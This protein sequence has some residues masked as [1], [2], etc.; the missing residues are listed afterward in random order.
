MQI[1]DLCKG[2]KQ[3]FGDITQ[4]SRGGGKNL[5]LKIAGQRGGG[6]GE[7]IRAPRFPPRSA[8]VQIYGLSVSLDIVLISYPANAIGMYVV[9]VSWYRA[10]SCP[11]TEIGRDRTWQGRIP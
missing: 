7:G 3:D 5:F 10:P 4:Q 2:A 11:C 8:P 9:L 6:G 1:Q